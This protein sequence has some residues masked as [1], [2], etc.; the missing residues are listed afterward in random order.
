M[1]GIFAG[2]SSAILKGMLIIG[3]VFGLILWGSWELINYL[4]IND[5]ETEPKHK[6]IEIE[7]VT[8]STGDTLS[9]DTL[10]VDKYFN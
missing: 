4:W 3:F 2:L 7:V 10:Y 1:E 8:T 9:V 6:V 5:P